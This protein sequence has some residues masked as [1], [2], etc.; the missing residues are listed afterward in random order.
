[1]EELEEA[2]MKLQQML[3]QRHVTPFRTGTETYTYIYIYIYIYIIY[4]YVLLTHFYVSFYGCIVWFI[5][6]TSFFPPLT[7]LEF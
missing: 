3:T 7:P 6:P 2:Q 5:S 4:I 1:M